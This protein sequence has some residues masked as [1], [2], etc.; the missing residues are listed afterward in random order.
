MTIPYHIQEKSKYK[1]I[2][3]VLKIALV[4][5]NKLC[6]SPYITCRHPSALRATPALQVSTQ[7]VPNREAAQIHPPRALGG[8]TPAPTPP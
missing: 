3:N 1:L 8:S 5:G 2:I 7:F 6:F 4:T